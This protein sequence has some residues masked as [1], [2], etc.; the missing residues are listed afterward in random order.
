MSK[1]WT[2]QSVEDFVFRIGSDFVL[3]IETA[4]DQA[5]TNQAALAKA[6]GV[7]DGRVSQILNNPGNL[8]LNVIVR[9]A[10]A[11]GYKASIMAYDD[12]DPG[13]RNGPVNAQI[14]S[15]CWGRAGRPKDFFE[16]DESGYAQ[17]AS[18]LNQI[19]RGGVQIESAA[20][21]T[22]MAVYDAKSQFFQ[23]PV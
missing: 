17:S 14:F 9:V 1:H 22:S 13:N 18:N 12:G 8:T 4:M 15:A 3:Q 20:G 11:L 16:L 19:D 10:R 6:I 7:S 21:T 5:N 23:V 2:E